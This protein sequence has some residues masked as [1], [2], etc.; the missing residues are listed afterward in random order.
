MARKRGQHR[1][2]QAFMKLVARVPW[3]RRKYSRWILRYME[4]SREKGRALPAELQ[5]LERQ[6]T[7]IPPGKRAEVI[8]TALVTGNQPETAQSRAVR[9]AMSR[10]QRQKSTG[11]GQRPGTMGGSRVIERR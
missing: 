2:Q 3:M 9:R 8:E 10:Q 5:R 11:R 6:L 7:R 4:K 1:F